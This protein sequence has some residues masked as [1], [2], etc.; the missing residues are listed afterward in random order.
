MVQMQTMHTLHFEPLVT[1]RIGYNIFRP[2]G[3]TYRLHT[4]HCSYIRGEVGSWVG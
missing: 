2:H 4:C 3:Q 1:D